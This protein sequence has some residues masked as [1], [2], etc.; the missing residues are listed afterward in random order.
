MRALTHL[1]Y[2]NYSQQNLRIFE[3][4]D[5]NQIGVLIGFGFNWII[6][7][8]KPLITSSNFILQFNNTVR[9]LEQL[10]V[11]YSLLDTI[12]VVAIMYE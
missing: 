12:L 11:Q 7:K 10:L 5:L 3:T 8:P 6:E 4:K 9:I 2:F 1:L